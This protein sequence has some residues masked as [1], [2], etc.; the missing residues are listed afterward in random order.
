MRGEGL[1][2]DGVGR[3]GGEV[4]IEGWSLGGVERVYLFACFDLLFQ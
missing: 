3:G 1:I 4:S 2:Y